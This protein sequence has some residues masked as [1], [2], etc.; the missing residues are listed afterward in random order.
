MA[1][2][3]KDLHRFGLRTQERFRQLK[4]AGMVVMAGAVP[5][6]KI[7]LRSK[8]QCVPNRSGIA[9]ATFGRNPLDLCI[10]LA[11]GISHALHRLAEYLLKLEFV[12]QNLVADRFLLPPDGM[13]MRERVAGNLVAAVKL[14][15]AFH[16][17]AMDGNAA[18]FKAIGARLHAGIQVKSRFQTVTVEELHQ[19]AV[20]LHPV[21]AA[22]SDGFVKF[23]EP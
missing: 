2:H 13:E 17:H 21:V 15:Q 20:R 10:E 5:L 19:A 12:L 7:R 4:Q 22:E 18:L 6:E 9:D 16:V 8:V 11:E 3:G 14:R 1:P 23:P